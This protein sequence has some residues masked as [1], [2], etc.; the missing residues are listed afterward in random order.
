MSDL[1]LDILVIP[2]YNSTTLGVADASTYPTNPPVVAAVT[3]YP[4][5]TYLKR[6]GLS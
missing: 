5:D 4:T 2:T 1:K 3:P 6:V